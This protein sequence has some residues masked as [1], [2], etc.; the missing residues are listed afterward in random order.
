MKITLVLV[1]FCA[2]LYSCEPRPETNPNALTE[3]LTLENK[4]VGWKIE[5]PAGWEII[6]EDES[7]ESDQLGVDAIVEAVDIEIDVTGLLN[8]LNIKKEETN[9][10]NICAEPFFEEY[11]GEWE[12]TNQFMQEILIATYESQGISPNISP[13]SIA[14]I[15]GLEFRTY[16]MDLS[17][18]RS[19]E[20]VK[21][22]FYSRLHNGYDLS[23]TLT[24]TDESIKEEM[25]EI[26]KSSTLDI[27][28][29]PDSIK[30]HY[31]EMDSIYN[32]YILNGEG[33]FAQEKYGVAKFWFQKAKEFNPL[34]S[35]AKNQLVKCELFI[36]EVGQQE[37]AKLEV[38][39][40]YN[41][42]IE[43]ADEYFASGSLEDA[44]SY[45]QR[46]VAIE[47]ANQDLKDKMAE[48]EKLIQMDYP[49]WTP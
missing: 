37:M 41:K 15:S 40:Q 14:E 20:K 9:F 19:G 49:E 16:T 34:E 24:F 46:A 30:T 47:P 4:E 44:Y 18:N 31:A 39:W 11:L 28:E 27:R 45:Y 48:T 29:L 1:F 36:D 38:D 7:R 26:W 43:K 17:E 25:I 5:V 6:D 22:T 42:V 13:V 12:A 2:V 10:L 35:Y 33:G 32:T 3:P 21:Q 23:A 8:L